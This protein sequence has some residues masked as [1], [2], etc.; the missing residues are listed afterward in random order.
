M[1]T[2]GGVHSMAPGPKRRTEEPEL[3]GWLKRW[4]GGG[5]D[6]GGGADDDLQVARTTVGLC[7]DYAPGIG[8][9][10]AREADIGLDLI[11]GKL[12]D[13]QLTATFFCPAKL[14]ETMP[15]RLEQIA[16]RGHELGCLGYADE[17]PRQL[18]GDALAQ[19][20]LACR[21]AF[22]R[23]GW[24]PAGYRYP[25]TDWDAR[26]NAVL[27]R[28]QFIYHAHHDHAKHPYRVARSPDLVRVP[29]CTDDRGLRRRQETV[30]LTLSKHLR[31]LRKAIARGT[32]VAVAFHPAILAED[33]EHMSHWEEWVRAAVRSGAAVGPLLRALPESRR[34]GSSDLTAIRDKP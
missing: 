11:L 17:E 9:E 34:P 30:N 4:T 31:Y 24:R 12:N 2:M 6:A 32:Y 15:G 8:F 19:M 23:R 7:F 16:S 5:S 1:R 3:L 21:S 25:H 20:I 13:M 28:Q 29:V 14:C 10:S 33:P 18:T 22:D 27:P 26:L